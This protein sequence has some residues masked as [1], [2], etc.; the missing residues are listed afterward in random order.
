MKRS[1]GTLCFTITQ[2]TSTAPMRQLA[3]LA[4]ALLVKFKLFF[5]N[6]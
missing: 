4:E 5:V 3:I 6:F 2:A 1:I